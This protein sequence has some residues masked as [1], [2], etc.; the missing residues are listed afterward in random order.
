MTNTKRLTAVVA[1]TFVISMTAFAGDGAPVCN[2][3]PGIMQSP[4]C[5]SAQLLSDESATQTDIP[6]TLTD[7]SVISLTEA[8]IDALQTLLTIF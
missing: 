4:P 5:A 6:T 3:D 2:P 7:G 1:L 8:T